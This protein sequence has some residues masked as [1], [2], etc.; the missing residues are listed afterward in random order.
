MLN[1]PQ[2]PLQ[3]KRTSWCV[4]FSFLV[5]SILALS[6]SICAAA[7][8]RELGPLSVPRQLLKQKDREASASQERIRREA[9]V[10]LA[11]GFWLELQT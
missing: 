3:E 9:M 2:P 7:R 6:S 1:K 11:A 8:S 5:T 10:H 4:T